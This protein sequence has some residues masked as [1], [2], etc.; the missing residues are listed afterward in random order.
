MNKEEDLNAYMENRIANRLLKYDDLHTPEKKLNFL[1]NE[2]LIPLPSYATF[3]LCKVLLG[4][5]MRKNK[6]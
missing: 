2:K 5:Q 4:L 6:N 1:F 3:T